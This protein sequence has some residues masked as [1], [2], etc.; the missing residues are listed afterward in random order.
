MTAVLINGI[1]N[2]AQNTRSDKKPRESE[3][4][5]IFIATESS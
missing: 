3:Y 2:S 4:G 5:P 1:P